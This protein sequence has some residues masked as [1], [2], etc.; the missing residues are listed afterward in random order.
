[1]LLALGIIT[2]VV[3]L[4]LLFAWHGFWRADQ[5]LPLVPA[6]LP[7]WP[8]VVAVVPARDEAAT[9]PFS[10]TSLI[11]QRYQGQFHIVLADDSSTDDTAAMALRLGDD[12]VS[13]VTVVEAGPLPAG[14]A[15]KTWALR[16]G[17]EEARRHSPTYYWFT[18]A[19][20]V[21]GQQV[22]ASLVARAEAD[23]LALASL[24]VKLP[25][26]AL[27]ERLLVPAYVFFFSLLYPFRAVSDPASRIA[28]AAGGSILVRSDALAAI[29]G[30]AAIKGA[31]IDDCAL[32]QAI[33]G[34]GRRIWLG[35]GER[36]RSLRRYERLADIWAMVTRSAYVQLGHSP[37]VLALTLAGLA[38]AFLA[39]PLLVGF[40]GP[41]AGLAGLVAWSLMSLAYWSM[42][43]FHGLSPLWAVTLPAAAALFAAMTVASAVAYYRGQPV[44]WRGRPVGMADVE[45]P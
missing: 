12:G 4:G 36:S 17:V 44:R 25:A 7:E 37:L 32:A 16:C 35:L 33:K 15:G 19:D 10:L 8:P 30:L 31:I 40:A 1:M 5:R 39:P 9:I 20:I 22:L 28:G 13:R 43:R 21:H 26:E 27:W 11:E 45:R 3:W 2:V 42:V 34:S 18:D 38:M 6:E 41:A 24:M 23:Q 29:G 14:W